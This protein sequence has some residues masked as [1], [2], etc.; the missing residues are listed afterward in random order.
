ML[1][2]KTKL[3]GSTVHGIGLF[4]EEFIPK[5]TKMWHFAS[6]FD[7]EKTCDEIKSLPES[8]QD[9][10]RHFGYLD[11]RLNRHILSFDDARFM[12]HS[13]NPNMVPDFDQ[14]KYGVGVATRDI[15]AGEEITIDYRQIE[16][17]SCF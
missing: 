7:L 17:E 5:G 2:V 14:D 11:Q 12:N 3:R 4:A 8:A 15:K 16:K 1:L 9:W 13:D 6:G 10:F